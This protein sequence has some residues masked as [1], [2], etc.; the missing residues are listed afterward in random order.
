ML[1]FK[2][3]FSSPS[4]QGLVG[5]LEGHG[6]TFDAVY[7]LQPRIESYIGSPLCDIYNGITTQSCVSTAEID[8]HIAAGNGTKE[9]TK[10][11][12]Q[13]GN[14]YHM[15]AGSPVN[16]DDNPT[17]ETN[18]ALP[19]GLNHAIKFASV[20]QSFQNTNSLTQVYGCSGVIRVG[21]TAVQDN[22]WWDGPDCQNNAGI[23]QHRGTEVGGL[24]L[25]PVSTSFDTADF[26]AADMYINN[27]VGSA[28]FRL[29]DS[30][31]RKWF[32]FTAQTFWDES[33]SN[34]TTILSNGQFTGRNFYGLCAE[35]MIYFLYPPTASAIQDD[36]QDVYGPF[37]DVN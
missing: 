14:N 7:S 28:S 12:D 29:D 37:E 3:I 18:A 16:T 4:E 19:S 30:T 2:G 13:S 22:G 27:D 6:T 15:I 31:E 32:G 36:L 34:G 9:I 20:G 33:Y 17:I 25:N 5:N 10:W 1:F 23:L 35:L 21:S 8:A 11:Y 24:K 26:P